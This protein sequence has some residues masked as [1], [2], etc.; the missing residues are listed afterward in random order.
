ME[1]I[2]GKAG[3]FI[4]I[5]IA[6]YLFKKIGLFKPEDNRTIMK[7]LMHVT[8]PAAVIASFSSY[9]RDLRL[10]AVF[11]IGLLLNILMLSI[12]Y[13]SAK[14]DK[15]AEKAF[16]MVNFS[17]YNIGTFAMPYLQTLLGNTG[18]IVAC[19]FDAGN[20]VMCTGMTYA[21]ASMV[22]GEQTGGIKQNFFKKLFSSVPFDVYLLMIILYAADLH[23]PQG[24][25][26]AAAAFGGANAFLAMFMI[27]GAF[28]FCGDSK[29]I[30]RVARVLI[31]RYSVAAAVSCLFYYTL[32]FSL[33]IKR[34][35]M[36]I[37]FAPVSAMCVIFTDRL[38]GDTEL[39]GIINSMSI[40]V[41]LFI[42]TVLVCV[43]GLGI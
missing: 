39:A 9:D 40:L 27:G 35:L 16:N 10:L 30:G 19:L 8:L 23:F 12:G 3:N 38:N 5:I 24:V 33:E 29:R 31:I 18:V 34:I 20:A 41:S 32:P 36:I 37:A 21:L 13:C 22:A 26:T 6:G 4:L 1:Y 7:L 17:G 28:E 11:F 43:W 14:K 42:M 25:Y 15:P 2:I